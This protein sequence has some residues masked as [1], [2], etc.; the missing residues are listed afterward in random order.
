MS[1]ETATFS[2]QSTRGRKLASALVLLLFLTLGLL[3]W[4]RPTWEWDLLGYL[5]C[6]EELDGLAGEE[7]HEAVYGRLEVEAPTEAV[8]E[9]RSKNPY[10]QRLAQ[11]PAAFEAQLPFYRGRIVYV[12]TLWA[13]SKLGASPLGAAFA[14]S[15]LAGIA[16]A[17]ILFRW[18]ARSRPAPVAAAFAGLGLLAAG[19]F[20][21]STLATPDMLA[22]C[23]AL[24]GAWALLGLG[25]VGLAAT[26]FALAVATRADHLLFVLPLVAW[27]AWRNG[28]GRRSLGGAA[29]LLGASLG[30][31][32]L[33]TLGRETHGWWTVFHHTFFGYKA[34]P[35]AETPPVDLAEA[36]AHG[37]RSLPQ[38]KAWRPLAFTLLGLGLVAS[39]LRRSRPRRESAGLAAAALAGALA[40]FA[41]LPVL[42]PR[43]ML[44][45]WS[46][47]VVALAL[48][49]D[50]PAAANTEPKEN[51]RT[52]SHPRP[53][54]PR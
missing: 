19:H 12:G 15:S 13:L 51:G 1:V 20:E 35:E 41:L 46:L 29:A 52:G 33:C 21:I 6:V 27:W 48:A 42:W 22:A 8:N 2:P 44:P 17:W 24:L 34:F 28:G 49:L 11:E 18:L 40:H 5:G 43:L 9:L 36:F 25:R 47:L 10:R 38:F 3:A 50:G 53:D 23:L 32:F 39:G 31:Y 14:I 30:A 54:S 16:L 37:L 45:Y 7:L 4:V 26:A